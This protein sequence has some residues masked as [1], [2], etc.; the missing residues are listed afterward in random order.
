MSYNYHLRTKRNGPPAFGAANKETRRENNDETA[1]SGIDVQQSQ[2]LLSSVDRGILQSDQ[3][4]NSTSARRQI[5]DGELL[6]EILDLVDARAHHAPARDNQ[7]HDQEDDSSMFGKLS[8]FTGEDNQDFDIWLNNFEIKFES[9]FNKP[10]CTDEKKIKCLSF[11]LEGGARAT[12]IGVSQQAKSY[13]DVV[14]GLRKRYVKPSRMYWVHQLRTTTIKE[15]ERYENFMGRID[16]IVMKAYPN[17]IEQQFN[18]IICFTDGLHPELGD[19][20]R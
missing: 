5:I 15:N 17:P 4:M 3:P 10:S 18:S 12:F 19:R 1:D 20:I 9:K 6:K 11:Y 13:S 14:L 2:T 16:Q 8:K 7:D